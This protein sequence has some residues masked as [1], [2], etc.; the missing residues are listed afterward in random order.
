M[1]KVNFNMKEAV[2]YEVIKRLVEMNGN[3]TRADVKLGCTKRTINRLI[4]R[5]KT[6]GKEDFSHD[7]IGRHQSIKFDNHFKEDIIH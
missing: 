3:K 2:K 1:R 4:H 7:N 5:Y 6:E